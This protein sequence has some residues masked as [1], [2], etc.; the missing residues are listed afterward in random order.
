MLQ[1]KHYLCMTYTVRIRFSEV[2][3][4]TDETT[5]VDW[6]RF[7][8][9]TYQRTTNN[10]SFEWIFLTP[11]ILYNHHILMHTIN[12]QKTIYIIIRGEVMLYS[13]YHG[14]PAV[15]NFCI[16]NNRSISQSK[17]SF[18]RSIQC[19]RGPPSLRFLSGLSMKACPINLPSAWHTW[20]AHLTAF[21]TSENLANW[22]H[23]ESA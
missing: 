16:S 2:Y 9:Y 15:L 10:I 17:S 12:V 11:M 6:N 14:S 4:N 13:F 18:T 3:L 1:R 7:T 21:P 22:V 23:Y 5:H 8:S 19:C 20:P